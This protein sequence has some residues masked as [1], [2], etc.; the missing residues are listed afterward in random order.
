MKVKVIKDSRF[1]DIKVRVNFLSEV[2][3]E[4]SLYHYLFAELLGSTSKKFPTKKALLEYKNSLYGASV[5]TAC[6]ITGNAC[7]FTM[8]ASVIND[9]FIKTDQNLLEEL[10][11]LLHELL[12][13]VKTERAMFIPSEFDEAIRNGYAKM[14]RKLDKPNLY[15]LYKTFE[16]VGKGQASGVVP[17]LNAEMFAKLDNSTAYQKYQTMLTNDRIDV[18]IIGDVDEAMTKDLCYKYFDFNQQLKLYGPTTYQLVPNIKPYYF[19]AKDLTQTYFTMMFSTDINKEHELYYAYVLGISILGGSPSSLLF[20]EVREKN[21]LCYSIGARG[22]YFDQLMHITSGV[23]VDKVDKALKL[24]YE[25]YEKVVNGD[26]SDELLATSK[27]MLLAS[28]K[29]EQ[30]SASLK[31]NRYYTDL[32]SQVPHCYDQMISLINQVDKAKVVEAFKHVNY[33][34]TYVVG[35]E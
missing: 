8:A 33:L 13:N 5:E 28:L 25:Q 12:I 23:Q 32:L 29:N 2:N 11:K 34:T 7:V 6:D 4:N 30:D 27:E 35:K 3:L 22:E 10:F 24:S 18:L 1:K 16:I 31:L 20:Q 15:S 19:E 26:F 14:V 17:S 21:S 9:K